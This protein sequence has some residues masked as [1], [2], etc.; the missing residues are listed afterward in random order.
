MHTSLLKV[1][2]VSVP[3]PLSPS[4]HA[5]V[6]DASFELFSC[7]VMAII[8]P[9]GAGKSSLLKAISGDWSYQGDIQIT[10][11][12]NRD[13]ERA[14]QLAVLPQHSQLDFDFSVNE[15]VML[16]RIPHA[17]GAQIDQDIVTE[18]LS[19]MDISYLNQRIY[20]ELSGG[21]KQRVQL[22]RVFAQIWRQQDAGGG[23]RLLILDEPTAA[24]DVGHQHLLLKAVR[25]FASKG[26]AV[27]MVL[28]DMNLAARYADKVLAMQCSQTVAFGAPENVITEQ[29]ISKLFDIDAHIL[30]HPVTGHP[31]VVS[32]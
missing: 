25:E 2:K 21:E 8:G 27:V 4:S 32:S 13:V 31:V 15:V 23:N 17:S 20:T 9:N 28:H 29:N 7:E 3:N 22:A 26:V 18:A 24:L 10:G 19:L 11:L 1:D 14:R 12:E 30:R 16:G 6:N 5:L